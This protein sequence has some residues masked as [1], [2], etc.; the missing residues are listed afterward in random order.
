M[1]DVLPQN[2]P[3]PSEASTTSFNY[4]D[5]ADGTG[6]RIFNG[7]IVSA[8]TGIAPHTTQIIKY[9]LHQESIESDG[10][11]K[12][13]SGTTAADGVA[14]DIDLDLTQF[15]L[16]QNIKGKALVTI[17]GNMTGGDALVNH[18]ACFEFNLIRWD[19]SSETIIGTGYSNPLGT[20]T[21]GTTTFYGVTEIEIATKSHFK[22]G[23][24]L[25]LNVIAYTRSSDAGQGGIVKLFIEPVTSGEELKVY[26][27]F[28]LDL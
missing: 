6:V 20:V 8:Q 24:V 4:T 16:P 28:D 25:R 11:E 13:K 9:I 17:N 12:F 1:A 27:P 26:V 7:M 15:N 3:V 5:I 23:D 22:I 2:F 19:G 21:T 18:S 14:F 10:A